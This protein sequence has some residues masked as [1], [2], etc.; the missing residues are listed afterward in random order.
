M[1]A[2]VTG[3][4]GFLGQRLVR[5]LIGRGHAVRALLRSDRGAAALREAGAEIVAGDALDPAALRRGVE[6]CDVVYHLA[7][8]RRATRREEFFRQNVESTRLLL[9]A[10]VA[11]GAARRRFVLAGSL[12]ACGPSARGRREDEPF[13]PR[14]WYGESKAE[15]ERVAFA[16]ADRIPVAVARP[17]RVM[18]PGDRENLFFFRIAQAGLLLRIGGGPRPLSWIDVDDCAR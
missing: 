8:I 1:L 3:A 9:D 6:A 2:F 15:A 14:E 4:G 16:Q 17:P 13:D 7:G 18:G 12:A 11:A 10:C 5:E